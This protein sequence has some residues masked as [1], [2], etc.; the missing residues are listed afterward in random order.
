[1][2]TVLFNSSA[3]EIGCDNGQMSA[4]KIH[5]VGVVFKR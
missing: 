5:S 2:T 1:M 3:Y 4:F